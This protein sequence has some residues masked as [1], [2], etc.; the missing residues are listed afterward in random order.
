MDRDIT[1]RD[2]LN[3]TALAIGALTMADQA[4]AASHSTSYPPRE[5]GLQGQRPGTF[6]KMHALRDNTFWQTAGPI[7][8]SGESY[9]LVVVGAGI[10]GLTAAHLYREQAG[11]KAR[12]LILDTLNDF[13][14]HA[15]RNE[16][17]AKNGKLLLG[18]GGSQSLQT[19]SFFSPAVRKVLADLGVEPERFSTYYDSKFDERHGLGEGFFF[20]KEVFG[21]DKLVKRSEKAADWVPQSPMNDK[22]KADLIAL[23]DQPI[24]YL[25]G[26]DRAAKLDFMARTTYR[27]FL[28]NTVKA[29]MQ[30]AAYLE[31][32]TSEYFGCGIDA[33]TCVDAWAI[34]NPG[35]AA[36]GLGEGAVKTQSPSGRLNASDPDDY[37][38]HFPDGNASIARL[39]VR[40]L[41]PAALPG[42]S[43]DDIVLA[44]C[45]YAQLDK[46]G[47]AT[48][49]RLNAPVMRVKHEGD[50]A[51][52]KQVEV[53]YLA[54]EKLMRVS[55]AHVVLAT[56]HQ[57]IP[58]LAPEVG[59]VQAAAMRDQQKIPL[60]Y[61]NVLIS[62]WKAFAKLGINGF[63]SPG[64]Y[65]DKAVMDFP[66]SM[67]GYRFARTPSDPMILHVGKVPYPGGGYSLRDQAL[68]GRYWLLSQTFEDF[69]FNI[70]D[71]LNRALGGAGF[72][73]ARDIEAITVNRW[74]H[75]YAY[76]YM[77]PWDAYWP[78]GPLPIE[79]ARRGWGRIAIANADAGAYAYAHSAIDQATRAVHELLGTIDLA[80]P[81]VLFPGP[82]RDM[83]GL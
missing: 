1:R 68:N 33:V 73:A 54:G 12:I 10:S 80:D 14:G 66:V 24:D 78:D 4:E 41:I 57:V 50:P 15:K 30:V 65:F 53:V 72:D 44:K 47:N 39:L 52:A 79:T 8:D 13:G 62:N 16:F 34:G 48:R 67:G 32:T 26:M 28:L 77:R 51:E 18:Y 69:E 20:A 17:R 56:F 81:P 64:H 45:D 9:D 36:M 5:T 19:P 3:G 35:F 49:I 25:P 46:P 43:M 75:G 59:Q 76:E 74:S 23:I 63:E 42:H 61:C 27:D 71:L 70:R 31:Q 83:I 2:F 7:A 22:A 40:K 11:R 82:P 58:Y 60:L 21:S 6:E 29:D 38:Y 37:I 55:A